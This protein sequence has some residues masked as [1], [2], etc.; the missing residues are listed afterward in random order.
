MSKADKDDGKLI[1]VASRAHTAVHVVEPPEDPEKPGLMPIGRSLVLHGASHPEAHGGEMV[2]HGV[3]AKI[4]RRWHEHQKASNTPLAGL[5][6]EVADDYQGSDDPGAFGFEPALGAMSG[7]D[8]GG[9]IVTHAPP[10]EAPEMAATSDT[11]DDGSPRSEPD[12]IPTRRS[13]K[14]ASATVSEELGKK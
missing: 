5:M 9:S 8:T 14:S 6:Y 3:D 2:N 12:V 10:V 11:P 1:S 13:Q 7:E 4:F